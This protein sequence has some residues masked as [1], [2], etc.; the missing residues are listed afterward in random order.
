MQVH[1][2]PYDATGST[3]IVEMHD[4]VWHR[5]GFDES[6]ST[7]FAPGVSDEKSV[8]R[9]QE[10]IG[11]ILQGHQILKNN[12]KWQSFN[13]I[14]NDTWRNGNVVLL[15]DAAHTAHFSIGSGTKLAMEDAIALREAL[16]EQPDVPAAL[17]GLRGRAPAGGPVDPARGPGEPGLVREHRAL[18]RTEPR[19]SSRSTR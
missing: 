19:S 9:V 3:V 11:D 17:H 10:L 6:T 16:D 14:S 2:Y 4:D 13:T 15:G 12:S 18:R 1:G 8:A 5:A 7:T